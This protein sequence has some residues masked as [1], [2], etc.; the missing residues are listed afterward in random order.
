MFPFITLTDGVVSLRPFEF[1]DENDLHKAVQESIPEL[2]PWM[3]WANEKYTTE[4]ALNFITLTRAYWSNGL[5]YA[6]AITDAK[7]KRFIGSCS[8]SHIHPVYHFC[9]LGYWVRSSRH[10]EGIAGRA[11][12]LVA[13]FAFEKVNLLRTEIV[14]AVGNERSK[15]VA[16]KIGAHYEGILLNRMILGTQVHDAHMFSL[17]PSDFGLVARL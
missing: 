17:L 8:L 4:T 14:I 3:S 15:R 5:L 7:T 9:N 6:F 13:R 12:R 16:E 11:A 10:R 1:G 2:H